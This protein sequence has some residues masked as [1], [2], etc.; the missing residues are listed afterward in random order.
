MVLHE[1]FM[2]YATLD[3]STD[4]GV[5]SRIREQL[6][7]EVEAKTAQK[8]PIF[9][10]KEN[11]RWSEDWRKKI[12]C[13][14]EKS[15]FLIAFITPNFWKSEYCRDELHE[16]LKKESEYGIS[17]LIFPIYYIRCDQIEN[18]NS[19][20][21]DPLIESILQRQM[22]SWVDWRD[23]GYLD[24][25]QPE[26]RKRIMEMA[27]DIKASIKRTSKHYERINRC[28]IYFQDK[29]DEIFLSNYTYKL[30]QEH[31]SKLYLFA[32]SLDL[33]SELGDKILRSTVESKEEIYVKSLN[34]LSIESKRLLSTIE[35]SLDYQVFLGVFC[36]LVKNLNLVYRDPRVS[37]QEQE[38]LQ[39]LRGMANA[40]RIEFKSE[41]KA[42][43]AQCYHKEDWDL[44]RAIEEN[45]RKLKLSR[46]DAEEIVDE[47]FKEVKAQESLEK[48][49]RS[50]DF[51]ID[52]ILRLAK[53]IAGIS[54]LAINFLF[55]EFPVIARR[56]YVRHVIPFMIQELVPA[57]IYTYHWTISLARYSKEWIIRFIV[58]ALIHTYHWTISL[59]RYSKEWIVRF[60]CDS[61][62]PFG[63]KGCFF[64]KRFRWKYF[65]FFI[66][67]ISLTV[68]LYNFLNQP[69]IFLSA[70]K[71]NFSEDA[72][73]SDSLMDDLIFNWITVWLTS[74]E[75]IYGLDYDL[76]LARNLTTGEWLQNIEA[77]VSQLA[78]ANEFY[79]FPQSRVEFIRKIRFDDTSVH[80]SLRIYENRELYS[81][82]RSAPKFASCEYV[83]SYFRFVFQED[84]WKIA[85]VGYP[86]KEACPE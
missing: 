25:Q 58:P 7:K 38:C 46:S 62:L 64:S 82:G 77:K 18:R 16:F 12:S 9:Q 19:Q 47:I 70:S 28:R 73:I 13:S 75:R 84:K 72:F 68:P 52:M 27:E 78:N 42:T 80:V 5:L 74:R 66:G 76:T 22:Y 59:A 32:N 1:A 4:G 15:T 56:F 48:I 54:K 3:D 44:D 50:L 67:A 20:K 36:S 45:R 79:M 65:L 60:L 26:A 17:D 57:L 49:R 39:E 33:S 53:K 51:F 35:L 21:A 11:I 55:L 37:A 40:A 29:L 2:S 81:A 31:L 43:F 69:R 86:H 41:F 24:I 14:L 63:R 71:E 10:D 61:V 83:D 34:S 23:Q 6:S 8:F 85:Q 30:S